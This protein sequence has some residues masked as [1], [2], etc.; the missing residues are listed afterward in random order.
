MSVLSAPPTTLSRAAA[1]RFLQRATFGPTPEDTSRLMAIGL[2]AWFAEQSTA[3][4]PQ[5][6]LDRRVQHGSPTY[7]LWEGFLAGPDQL[8]KRIGYALSQIFVASLNGVG[9]SRMMAYADL[10]EANAFGTYR[11]LIEHITRSQAMGEYLTYQ[12]NRAADPR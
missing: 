1:V 7:A 3:T 12:R 2:D 10:L 8:R 4:M 9:N 6:H 5:S 11:D